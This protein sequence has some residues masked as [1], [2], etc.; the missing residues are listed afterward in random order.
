MKK[1]GK[2][3]KSAP[4]SPADKKPSYT[5]RVFKNLILLVATFFFTQA[6]R[7]DG[8]GYQWVFE[9]LIEDNLKM[10][11]KYKKLNHDERLQAKLGYTAAY[12]SFIA[13]NT[14]E[15]AVILMAPD[16]VF[17]PPGQKSDFNNFIRERGWASYFVY[18]RKLVYEHEKEL[19]P[20]MYER[21]THVAIAN[22]WGYQKLPFQVPNK[23][24][25]TIIPLPINQ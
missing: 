13:K 7:K 17:N 16:T 11:K 3:K 5:W 8:A 10:I 18:P 25:H 12:L 21:V 9:N 24:K 23:V 15:N 4:G 20:D 14:P 19:F 6:I 2:K 1:T 22:Y